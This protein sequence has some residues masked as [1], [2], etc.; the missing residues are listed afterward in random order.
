MKKLICA[1]IVLVV[2][3]AQGN[4][5]FVDDDAPLGGDGISCKFTSRSAGQETQESSGGQTEF[6]A[7]RTSNRLSG[8]DSRLFASKLPR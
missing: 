8:K 3:S 2:S 4:T 6:G 7:S 1:V 5:I